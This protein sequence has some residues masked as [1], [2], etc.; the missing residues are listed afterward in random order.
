MATG[1]EVGEP[2]MAEG[3]RMRWDRLTPEVRA[4]LR[5]QGDTDQGV[6]S[7]H[8]MYMY[9]LMLAVFA[10]SSHLFQDHPRLMWATT[11]T[12]GGALLV[13]AVIL[14]LRRRIYRRSPTLWR[15]LMALTVAC[16]SAA[17]GNL[18]ACVLWF[19]GPSAWEFMI[20]QQWLAGSAALS[21]VSFTPDSRLA[22][23]HMIPLLVPFIGTAIW[24]GGPQCA[25][26][27]I[28][29]FVFAIFM[30]VSQQR[31]NTVYWRDL[32]GRA[33]EA[34]RT[35]ELELAQ[36]AA[37]CANVAKS[38][39]L[40]NMSHEIR[41][42]MHGIL[43]MAQILHQSGLNAEQAGD[44]ATLHDSAEALLAILNDVL[45]LSKIEAG[46]MA[47]EAVPFDLRG[48]VEQVRQILFSQ[49]TVKGLALTCTV[50]PDIPPVLRGDALRLRQVLLNLGGNAV[51]FTET[52]SIDI[53]VR[54]LQVSADSVRLRFAVRDTGIG[55]PAGKQTSIFEEFSQVD[56]S[57]TRRFGGT[58]LG[59]TICS[60]LIQLMH[61]EIG[62]E[63]QPAVGSTFWFT[64]RFDAA[65][66]L[67]ARQ[68]VNATPGAL[69]VPLS[70]LVA[71]DNLVNQLVAK[72]LLTGQGHSVE[73]VPNGRA[74]V[75]A[76]A[77][78]HF[79]LILMDNQMPELGGMEAT[80]ILRESGCRIPI[81]AV[82]ASAMVGDRE[83]F[84]AAGMD[85]YL[86]KPFQPEELY[87]TI[88]RFAP[89]AHAPTLLGA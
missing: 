31:L 40:A 64:C 30:L 43:A 27:A 9:P 33:L 88:R 87:A 14:T 59:L 78:R 61:G 54:S 74:A 13:R 79:D 24:L 66:E 42:P 75:A 84:L 26:L 49:A 77:D 73:V 52:G 81:V 48:T 56:G 85:D 62:V 19:Y 47:L 63:S 23:L 17:L 16:V 15:A 20:V 71:E 45:D 51:K 76:V 68:A 39:F 7:L 72:R 1:A 44:L 4:E 70:I 10:F 57:I 46:K 58:G 6:R 69:A 28:A 80:R 55:I 34:E 67:P 89:D 32:V 5:E 3:S 29:G 37:E 65:S 82:S 36:Q 8:G 22:R 18:L 12:V 41:T 25:S 11:G 35:R 60:Q 86:S 21:I 2:P 38:Q 53:D 50:A 83:R